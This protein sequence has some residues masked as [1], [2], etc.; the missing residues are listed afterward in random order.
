MK[1]KNWI[2]SVIGLILLAV[3]LMVLTAPKVDRIVGQEEMQ[4]EELSSFVPIHTKESDVEFEQSDVELLAKWIDFETYTPEDSKIHISGVEK[5][6]VAQVIVYRMTHEPY[7]NTVEEVLTQPGQFVLTEEWINIEPSEEA[8]TIAR[9]ALSAQSDDGY[10]GFIYNQPQIVDVWFSDSELEVLN[11]EGYLN[12]GN[13][14]Y[15]ATE[16]YVFWRKVQEEPQLIVEIPEGYTSYLYNDDKDLLR[17]YITNPEDLRTLHREGYVKVFFDG[18]VKNP[19]FYYV[20]EFL[21]D[22]ALVYW[23]IYRLPAAEAEAQMKDM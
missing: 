17:N 13:L 16:Y 19:E 18:H 7:P 10:E 9:A 2:V 14:E 4:Y 8:L 12:D 21:E 11:S 3:L 20:S 5:M 22:G 23:K 1:T 6:V 15:T